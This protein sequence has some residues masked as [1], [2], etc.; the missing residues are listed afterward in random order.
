LF[1][2]AIGLKGATP[3][4]FAF[5]PLLMGVPQSDT[6]FDMVFFVVLFSIAIQGSLLE[7]L[8]RWLKLKE[9]EQQV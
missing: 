4:V 6:I 1:V 8:A 9:S 7:P 5:V 2:S 3:I